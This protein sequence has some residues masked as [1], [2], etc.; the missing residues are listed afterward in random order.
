MGRN[1]LWIRKLLSF[2]LFIKEKEIVR[3]QEIIGEFHSYPF[4][5]KFFSRILAGRLNDWLMNCN[6]LLEFQMGFVKGRK[7]MDNIL[8]IKT[9]TDKYLRLKRGCINF[10]I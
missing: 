5:V 3:K 1:F 8:I 2:T 10:S 9:M 7:P 4:W 6:T